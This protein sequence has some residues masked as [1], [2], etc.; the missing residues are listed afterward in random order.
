[1]RVN[2]AAKGIPDVTV[3]DS[4]AWQVDLCSTD[5]Q[6]LRTA[7]RERI[8]LYA[9][10]DGAWVKQP[11]DVTTKRG[12]RC[13]ADGIHVVIDAAE[14]APSA[15]ATDEGWSDCRDYRVSVPETSSFAKTYV[16]MC[17]RTRADTPT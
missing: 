4:L 15:S 1:M 10:Q 6:L 3:E 13:G 11:S 7:T 8:Q 5:A 14:K 2:Y 16:D 9:R 12:D 17:V